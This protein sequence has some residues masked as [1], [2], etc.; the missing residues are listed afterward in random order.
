MI[1]APCEPSEIE[2]PNHDLTH[3]LFQPWSKSC[4]KSKTQAEPHTRIVH[5][6]EDSQLPSDQRDWPRCEKYVE[7]PDGLNIFSMYV[8]SVG[9]GTSTIVETKGATDMFA[10]TWVVKKLKCL[11]FSDI[12]VQCDPETSLIE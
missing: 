10:M 6:T 4:V 7:A 3:I 9:Y 1:R 5:I 11:G 12:I 8:P 2:K